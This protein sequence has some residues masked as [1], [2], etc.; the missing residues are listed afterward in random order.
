MALF[1]L[2][3]GSD[4]QDSA[5]NAGD[6]GLIPGSGRSSPEKNVNPLQHSCLENPMDRGAGWAIVHGVAE[7]EA[8]VQ[9]TLSLCCIS[10]NH[11]LSSLNYHFLLRSA[12]YRIA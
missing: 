6:P 5:C 7:S 11:H 4:G 2:P 3:G 12:S 1:G 10:E 8:T 9:L